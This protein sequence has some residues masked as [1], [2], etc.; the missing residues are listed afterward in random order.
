MGKLVSLEEKQF[1]VDNFN[2]MSIVDIAKHLGRRSDH[3]G[4]VAR[5]LGLR[6]LEMVP[7]TAEEEDV[8]RTYFPEW[9]SRKCMEL[10]PSR[11]KEQIHWKAKR[12]DVYCN[13]TK[14]RVNYGIKHVDM[15]KDKSY[16]TQGYIVI[17]ID[18]KLRTEQDVI[19]EQALGRCL[20]SEEVVHHINEIKDDN[21]LDNLCVLTRSDHCKLH[22]GNTSVKIIPLSMLVKR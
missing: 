14:Q 7:W 10:L 8:I 3:I 5:K 12:L 20:T 17:K 19:A 18:G 15:E 13:I 4:G 2:K 22:H 6:K 1:I 21:Y 9:G 16:S 11:T